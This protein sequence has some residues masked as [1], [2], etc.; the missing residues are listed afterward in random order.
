MGAMP[1][2]E[3]NVELCAKTKCKK[4]KLQEFKFFATVCNSILLDNTKQRSLQSCY[5]PLGLTAQ[6]T[7]NNYPIVLW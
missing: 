3:D 5:R 4:K 6:Q 7:T 2:L 1:L